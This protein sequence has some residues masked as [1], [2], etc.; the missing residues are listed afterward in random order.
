MKKEL[1]SGEEIEWVN[2]YN[3]KCLDEISPLLPND[4]LALEWLKKECRPI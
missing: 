3:K 2:K 1:L 4:V